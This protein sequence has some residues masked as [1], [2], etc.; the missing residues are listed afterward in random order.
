MTDIKQ[1]NKIRNL[2]YRLYLK[3]GKKLGNSLEDWLRAE[4]RILNQENFFEFIRYPWCFF[5]K[6]FIV[7]ILSIWFLTAWYGNYNM[8]N[9]LNKIGFQLPYAY[10]FKY[11]GATNEQ[12]NRRREVLEQVPIEIN[13]NEERGFHFSINNKNVKSLKDVTLTLIFPNGTEV[14]DWK[15]QGWVEYQPNE[16]YSYHFD[17]NI[18][19]GMAQNANPLKLK[20]S[21]KRDYIINYYISGE[22][23]QRKD[24]KFLIRTK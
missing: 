24:R 1:E 5:N 8:I 10:E 7:A 6:P 13:V 21:E 11:R 15:E 4:K 17:P 23:I 2:A 18:H 14:K 19:N 12:G 9:T 20:F 22:D 16:Q 3:K